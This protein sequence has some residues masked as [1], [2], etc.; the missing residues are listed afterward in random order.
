MVT[1]AAELVLFAAKSIIKVS[2]QVKKALIVNVKKKELVIP[3]PDFPDIIDW[4]TARS[5]FEDAGDGFVLEN[6]RIKVLLDKSQ[7]SNLDDNEKKEFT[8]FHR[9]SKS[10]QR[11]REGTLWDESVSPDDFEALVTIVQWE[12]GKNPN[13]S[14]LQRIAGTLVEIAVDYF[15]QNEKIL[16]ENSKEHKAL[17]SF[18]SAIDDVKFAETPIRTLAPELFIV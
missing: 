18:L 5:F 16:N 12:R 13:S 8:L 4:R 15:I 9:E 6:S 17:R 3:L 2:G 7:I 11:A 14:T 1:E 10:I